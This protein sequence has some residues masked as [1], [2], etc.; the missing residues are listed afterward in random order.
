MKKETVALTIRLPKEEL[1]YIKEEAKRREISISEY[2]R[3]SCNTVKY[4]SEIAW[5]NKKLAS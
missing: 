2:V 3:Q 1:D 5:Q 4:R